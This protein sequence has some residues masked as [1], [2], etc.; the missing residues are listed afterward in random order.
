MDSSLILPLVSRWAH[1]GIAILLV[2]GTAFFRLAVIPALQ[3]DNTELLGR[4]RQNWKKFVHMGILIFLVSGFYNFFTMIPKHRGDGL[5]HALV[6]IK[7]L[8]ALFIF[9]LASVLVGSKP[10]SQKYRDNVKK[11]TA[12]MLLVAAV[13][14]GISGFLKVREIPEPKSPAP[15]IVEPAE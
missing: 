2:G 7:I 9:F 13:I 1:V 11:W 15:A 12:V 10:S 8:L 3:G 6:G 4:I 5:Y 14:V